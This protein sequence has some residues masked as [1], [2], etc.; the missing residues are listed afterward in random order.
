MKKV[1]LIK[2]LVG[3]TLAASGA[4]AVG[5]ALSN[6]KAEVAEAAAGD[7]WYLRGSMNGWTGSDDYEIKENGAPLIVDLSV[8]AEFKVAK[9]P[10]NWGTELTTSTGDASGHGITFTSGSN[11]VVN[12]AGKYAFTVKDG[13]LYVDFGEFYYSGGD[14]NFDI[15][16]GST[17]DHPKVIVNGSSVKYTLSSGYANRFKLRNNNWEKGVFSYYSLKDGDFYG[18]FTHP[19]NA[20][21]IQPIIAGDYDVSVALNNRVWTVRIVPHG[22]DPDDTSFV[23]VLDKYGDKLNSYHFSH[24]FDSHGREMGWPGATMETYSGTTHVYKQEFWVGMEKIIFN[25][26]NDGEG[27][28]QSISYDISGVNSK[29]GKCLILDDSTIVQDGK[30]KW[31]SNTWV[32]PETAKFIE[33][34]LHFQNFKESD[35]SEGNACK[36]TQGYYAKAKAAYEASSFEPYREELCTLSWAVERLQAWAAANNASFTI[37]NNVGSFGVNSNILPIN[38]IANNENTNTIAIIVIISLVSVTAIGGYFF[39]KRRQEN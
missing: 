20:D 9:H 29:A 28:T 16:T 14:N 12:S 31:N 30:T 21:D 15:D 1:G 7:S 32:N 11:S 25:N 5:S 22:V 18:S 27:N 2:L 38:L 10:S 24:A 37:S 36:G 8:G 3:L 19:D 39:I 4:F 23:Y 26:D 6:K 17:G 13:A 34:Y 33:N 35:R